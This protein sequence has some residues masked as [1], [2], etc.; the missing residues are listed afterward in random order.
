MVSKFD[1]FLGS[2]SGQLAS[3]A[4]GSLVNGLFNIGAAKRQYKYQ[5]KLQQQQ[6]DLNEQ[7]ANN[8]FERQKE[9]YNIQ[10][11]YNDPSNVKQRYKDAG[12]NPTAAFGTAGSYTPA[13]QSADAPQGGGAGLGSVPAL[14]PRDP[15][16][17]AFRMAQIENINAQTDKI[18]GDT[19]DPNE[20]RR[21]QVLNNNLTEARVIGQKLA[22]DIS[23]L[24]R[25]FYDQT[26]QTRVAEEQQKLN[27][28]AQ[29]YQ[30]SVQRVAESASRE[31]LNDQQVRESVER[32]LLTQ[33]QAIFTKT[34]NSWYGKISQAN[35]DE[36]Y[37]RIRKYASE[38]D[39]NTARKFL[40]SAQ[41]WNVMGD[42]KSKELDNWGKRLRNNL[43]RSS[44]ATDENGY[45]GEGGYLW[46]AIEKAFNIFHIGVKL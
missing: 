15:I 41:E 34:Q 1:K 20:T 3:G 24:D 25:T 4:V 7:A 44:Y 46:R 11:E 22:N 37:S 6:F 17:Q 27:N 18:R 39:L 2:Q 14:V 19:L 16:E 43:D 28:L 12:I 42:T 8:A 32:I 45:P 26:L 5:S 31:R 30:E 9:F 33:A 29:Q 21:G 35:I 23:E 10:N 38:I 40:T 13:Q 36:L